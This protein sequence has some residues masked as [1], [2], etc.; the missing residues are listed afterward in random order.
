MKPRYVR[1]LMLL[2]GALVFCGAAGSVPKRIGLFTVDPKTE[3]A[4]R[5]GWTE[6][7][8][9]FDDTHY[10]VLVQRN[11]FHSAHDNETYTFVDPAFNTVFFEP[12]RLL[13][14]KLA[15]PLEHSTSV[16]TARGADYT[17]VSVRL[18]VDTSNKTSHVIVAR[19]DPGG[20]YVD[21]RPVTIELFKFG[22]N[23]E[24]PVTGGPLS[25]FELVDAFT[26]IKCYYDS[27]DALVNELGL[28]TSPADSRPM[29]VDRSAP[30]TP[31][32]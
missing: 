4:L 31:A 16:S 15:F 12:G 11:D 6:L 29:T 27:N 24:G 30:C 10:H 28:S 18:L 13:Y 5:V 20:T 25:A 8:L 19:R 14:K 21:S 3:V 32:R 17:L 23:P 22:K 7:D 9:A 26:T 2:L 1:N